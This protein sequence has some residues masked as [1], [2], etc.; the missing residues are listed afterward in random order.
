[1]SQDLYN[2]LKVDKYA[3]QDDIRKAYRK[4]AMEYHPDKNSGNKEAE[5][6]FKKINEAYAVLSDP[7]KKK[8]YDDYGS[9]GDMPPPPPDINE[10]FRS[11]FS[12]GPSFSFMFMD[13]QNAPVSVDLVEVLI[14]IND[15]YYGVTKKIDFELLEKCEKCNGTGA[16]DPSQIINCITCK[17]MGQ[18]MHRVGPF[19][20]QNTICPSCMGR[21]QIIKTR[22][23]ACKGEKTV[24]SRQCF[25]LK[26]PKGIPDNHEMRMEGKGSYCVDRKKDMLF[27]FKYNIEKPYSI[28][29]MLNVTYNVTITIEELL[30]GFKKQIC[31]YKDMTIISSDGYFNPDKPVKIKEKGL[32]DVKK[33][34]NADLYIRFTV[35]YVESERLYK[36]KDVLGKIT[37]VKSIASDDKMQPILRIQDYV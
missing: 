24:Y 3:S 29:P 18:I 32:F 27:K 6:R 14:D 2:L 17:G 35:I 34:K 5:E 30:G 21:K 19:F 25:E 20:T 8:N 4:L 28:D 26:I 23:F 15:V 36:Y 33:Q 9:V 22:C 13:K 31:L 37:R 12:E 16:Q 11:M 10:I 7:E 1:M